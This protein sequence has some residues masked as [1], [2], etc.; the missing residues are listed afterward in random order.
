MK[1]C[2]KKH[3]PPTWKKWRKKTQWKLYVSTKETNPMT[4][5]CDVQLSHVLR[6]V[7]LTFNKGN[8]YVKNFFFFFEFFFWLL[9]SLRNFR[10]FRS[11][12]WSKLSNHS[13]WRI[14]FFSQMRNC[15]FFR[16]NFI[17]GLVDWISEFG[18]VKLET[19]VK[20]IVGP[21]SQWGRIEASLVLEKHFLF[22]LK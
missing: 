2:V 13:F 22:F 3:P 15:N 14:W 1:K 4:W 16:F 18:Y 5:K 6:R 19:H 17:W 21:W 8:K 12:W 10:P 20:E 11:R 7:K 9:F